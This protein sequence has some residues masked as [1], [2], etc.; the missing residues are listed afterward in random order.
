MTAQEEPGN[1]AGTVGTIGRQAGRGLRWSL[2]GTLLTR[3]GS[4]AMGL[5]LAR[6]LAPADFGLYAIALAATQF[7]MHVNDAGLIAATVQWRGKLEEMAPTAS[8]LAVVFS[9]GVYGIF[10]V[11]APYFSTLAGSEQATGVVRLLTAVILVDG[12]T[13]VR[14]GA[15]MRHFEQDKLTKANLAGVLANAAIAV[16]LATMGAGAYSFAAG[17]F[18]ASVVTGVLVFVFA[19]VPVRI[20]VDRAIAVRL[21]RFGLPLAASLGLESVLM[22]ADYVIVG[23]RLGMTMLGFY[24][25]AFNVS[26]W[27]PGLIGTAIRYVSIAGF[28]RLAE[29]D[30]ESL[31]EGVR[32]SVPLLVAFVLPVAV[33]MATLAHAIII[34]LYGTQWNMA[35]GVLRFLA[36]LMVVRMLTGLA[37]D[38]LTSV[39]ATRATVWLNA[40]WAVALVAALLVGIGLDGIRGAAIAH[41]VVGLVVA[42]PL[43]V[44]ALQRSGV[45]L[46]PVLPALVRPLAGA[47]AAAVVILLV[48]RVT[49]HILLLELVAAGGAG[50]VVYVLIV[51][52]A[53]QLK[54]LG[55]RLARLVPARS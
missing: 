20:A 14:A 38:I 34:T 21:L 4:F 28:S 47:A 32:R 55:S 39:G 45:N 49:G 8:V 7:V 50:L 46:R 41:A 31:A 51:V 12:I 27:V 3:M 52:P 2:F 23:D 54:G 19:R 42:L 29:G 26:S 22:N 40:G 48:S 10:W 13:A 44:W 43:A 24:L 6:L 11:G 53:A 1:D 18:G 25:L 17:Q 16:S 30:Q 36:V 33:V 15:L 9:T 5:V 35:A 37:F